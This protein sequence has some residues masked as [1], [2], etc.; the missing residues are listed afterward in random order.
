[1]T[2]VT[3]HLVHRA[4]GRYR[5]RIPR[6][7]GDVAFFETLA[8][9]LS[10]ME[11][12][13]AVEANP[14]TGGVLIRHDELDFETLANALEG[15]AELNEAYVAPSRFSEAVEGLNELDDWINRKSD[16]GS[17]LTSVLFLV[18]V[19]LGLAQIARGQIL[20]PATSLLWYAL[21]LVRS[22]RR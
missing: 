7:R 17:T 6:C 11:E 13:E 18:L 21:D 16:G 22:Q 19:T 12:V 10:A 15:H 5:L 2:G 1:M 9:V 8:D 4:P 3:A 20:A 14:R